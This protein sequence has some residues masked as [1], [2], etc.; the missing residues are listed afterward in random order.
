MVYEDQIATNA[1]SYIYA[2][3]I[4][5][6]FSVG[7]RAKPGVE[8]ERVEQTA[9]SVLKEFIDKGPTQEEVDRAKADYFANFIKG[10][11]R[12]GGFGGKSDVLAEN[13]VYGKD[14]EYYKQVLK[15]IAGATV[16]DVHKVVKDWL[17]SG[18]HTIVC[19]PFPTYATSGVEADRSKLPVLTEQP[20]S[21]FPDYQTETLKNGLKIVLAKRKDVPTVSVDLIVDAGYAAD[22]FA[23]PGTATLTMDLLDEGT[24]SLTALQISDKLQVLGGSIYAFSDLDASYVRMDALKPA[25]DESL[26]LFSD[27]VLNPAFA[28]NEFKRLQ[29][30]QLN[31]IRRE[32]TQPVAMAL[33]VFPKFLYGEGHAYSQPMTGS[34]YEETVK[35]LTRDDALKFYDTWL[36]PNNATLVVVGDFEMKDLVAAAEKNFG[37][38]KRGDVPKRTYRL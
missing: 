21:S 16:A 33:R 15:W 2:R 34:G 36:K 12:I 3:E 14:P 38:W 17:T 9:L 8:V 6:M 10:M 20:P 22:Q 29:E 23:K 11:E 19:Q 13:A 1:N 32:R 4:A 18:R 25:F 30:E 26:A 27:I 35:A 28:P 31:D 24:K 7:A 37:K 5:G